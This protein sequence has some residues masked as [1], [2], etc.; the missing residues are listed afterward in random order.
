[1]CSSDLVAVAYVVVLAVGLGLAFGARAY[2]V[3]RVPMVRY[4]ESLAAVS[5]TPASGAAIEATLAA[6]VR[7]PEVD[8]LLAKFQRDRGQTLVAYIVPRAYMM[9]HLIADVGEHEAHH[10]KRESSGFWAVTGHLLEMYALKP[11]RQ[12]R[13]GA[14]SPEK[15]IIFTEARTPSGASV[16]LARALDADVLR[17]PLFLA[18]VDGNAVTVVMQ[19]PRR[20]TW[21]TIPV[22]AF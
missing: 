9:Q 15:R 16:P 11:L 4:S 12:L 1:V 20:H 18:E 21:G 22:P 10:G 7:N 3:S 6:A 14:R 5:L 13:D 8:G 19:T 2:S 17:L